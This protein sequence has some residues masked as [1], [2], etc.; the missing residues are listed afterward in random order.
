ML[1]NRPCCVTYLAQYA[2]WVFN[3]TSL[4]IKQVYALQCIAGTSFVQCIVG[5]MS[6]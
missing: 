4:R 6:F 2:N 5:A 3:E 1:S